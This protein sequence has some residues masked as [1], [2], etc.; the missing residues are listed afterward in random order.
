MSGP[1]IQWDWHAYKKKLGH[2]CHKRQK[3]VRT[4]GKDVHLQTSQRGLEESNSANALTS[5]RLPPDLNKEEG[6]T[7]RE[8]G[9]DEWQEG[10]P[11]L[12]TSEAGSAHHPT[13][14]RELTELGL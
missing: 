1:L 11:Q 7:R 5:D 8:K 2:K 9:R 14:I 12:R 4:Q 10:G 6:E 3:T 13:L